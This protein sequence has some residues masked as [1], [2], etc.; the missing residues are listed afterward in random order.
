MLK[1]NKN[2]CLLDL[3]KVLPSSIKVK[4]IESHKFLTKTPRSTSG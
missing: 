3:L 1:N 2:K 4:S